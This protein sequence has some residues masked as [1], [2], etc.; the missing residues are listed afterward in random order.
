VARRTTAWT[1]AKRTTPRISA[2]RISQ[3]ID[4]AN[5]SASPIALM[6]AHSL[7][8]SGSA[9]YRSIPLWGIRA[10]GAASVAAAHAHELVVLLRDLSSHGGRRTVRFISSFCRMRP[11]VPWRR[12][13]VALEAW[14]GL[15][16]PCGG[17]WLSSSARWSTDVAWIVGGVK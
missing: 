4:P 12:A 13:V 9:S 10:A 17:Y 16:E 11:S 2:H 3:V 14:D 7:T 8:I 15:F 6:P 1:T 5:A